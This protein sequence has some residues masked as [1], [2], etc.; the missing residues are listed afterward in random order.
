M[1]NCN[2]PCFMYFKSLTIY[3]KLLYFLQFK[4][5]FFSQD[6]EGDFPSSHCQTN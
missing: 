3:D 2:M 4:M 1:K 5:E 6:G